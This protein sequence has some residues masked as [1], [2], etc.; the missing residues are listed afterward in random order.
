MTPFYWKKITEH[1]VLVALVTTWR[2]LAIS[3]VADSLPI[4][5]STLQLTVLRFNELLVKGYHQQEASD[6]GPRPIKFI[7][8]ETYTWRKIA[9]SCRLDPETLKMDD[10]TVKKVTRGLK[11][12]MTRGRLK[13]LTC[14]MGALVIFPDR[15]SRLYLDVPRFGGFTRDALKK[16]LGTLIKVH[17]RPK[18]CWTDGHEFYEDVVPGLDMAHERVIHEKE[19]VTSD[20]VT[21][22]G[23][24][25][26]W[27]EFKRW[28]REIKSFKTWRTFRLNVM[29]WGITRHLG[30]EEAVELMKRGSIMEMEKSH[31][32][33]GLV[34]I[35][36]CF[37]DVTRWA[38]HVQETL[39]GR[40][41]GQHGF[42]Q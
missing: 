28:L 32:G 25:G 37:L 23:I 19:F 10:Y 17:G 16:M 36:Q 7:L 33:Q 27:S 31:H 24:E 8:D 41:E 5:R 11:I 34:I 38:A 42:K 30:I 35:I 22:N 20:G 14:V 18:K 1:L 15:P 9:P 39:D 26:W 2:G 3:L 13:A 12:K 6:E 29:A 4:A 40:D 21:T